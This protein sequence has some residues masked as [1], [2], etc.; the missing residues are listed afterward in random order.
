MQRICPRCGSR[1]HGHD[2][3]AA[4][5]RLSLNASRRCQ[6]CGYTGMFPTVAEED[7]ASFRE[8][9]VDQD[10]AVRPVSPGRGRLVI[11]GVLFLLGVPAVLFGGGDGLLSGVLAAAVGAAIIAQYLGGLIRG[12]TR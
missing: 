5:S 7:V 12:G 2:P 4:L 8:E 3:V 6:D 9:V 11:G 1:E 10:I